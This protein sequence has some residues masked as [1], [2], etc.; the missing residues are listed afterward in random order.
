MSYVL[1]IEPNQLQ[2]SMLRDIVAANTAS[3]VVVVGSARSAMAAIE[4]GV[5]SV[6]LVNALLPPSQESDLVR[7][8]RS[9]PREGAPEIL[10]T[11]MFSRTERKDGVLSGLAR[12]GRRQ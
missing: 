11:P 5:P 1:A 2:A 9:L 3:K 7:Q 4:D 12:F 10:I 6:I 8:L